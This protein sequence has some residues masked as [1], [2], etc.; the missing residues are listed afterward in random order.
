MDPNTLE[1]SS[2]HKNELG[3][4]KNPEPLMESLNGY[5]LFYAGDSTANI[6]QKLEDLISDEFE[7]GLL[8]NESSMLSL[9]ADALEEGGYAQKGDIP[10][11][12]WNEIFQNSL[13]AALADYEAQT[14][15][16]KT[17][18]GNRLKNKGI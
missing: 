2:I 18:M 3:R 4:T 11:S 10:R 9:I 13:T 6:A 17:E 1:H 16:Q 15:Q 5:N 8:K 7:Y 14:P 12:E